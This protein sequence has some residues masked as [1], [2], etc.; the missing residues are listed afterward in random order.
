MMYGP[1]G[2]KTKAATVLEVH[3]R[4]SLARARMEEYGEVEDVSLDDDSGKKVQ[5]AD[6]SFSLKNATGC[7]SAWKDHMRDIPGEA[8]LGVMTS[9]KMKGTMSRVFSMYLLFYLD[10]D[11]MMLEAVPGKPFKVDEALVIRILGKLGDGSNLNVLVDFTKER[12]KELLKKV[13][14]LFGT[15]PSKKSNA[16]PVVKL[17]SILSS[18]KADKV[19]RMK[20]KA[21][22]DRVMAAYFAYIYS[23]F[24]APKNSS[25]K[26]SDEVLHII[27]DPGAIKMFNIV[28]CILEALQ[29]GARNVRAALENGD[30]VIMDG[31]LIL[32]LIGF[33]EHMIYGEGATRLEGPRIAE[34]TDRQLK[35]HLREFSPDILENSAV[36]RLWNKYMQ[37][38]MGEGGLTSM[39][40]GGNH[41]GVGSCESAPGACGESVSGMMKELQDRYEEELR[42]ANARLDSEED[43]LETE[44]IHKIDILKAEVLRK[45]RIGHETRRSKDVV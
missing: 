23:T 42:T 36:A 37:G 39:R 31:C 21:G 38:E 45:L 13:H 29:C 16:V 18:A 40:A 25:P 28:P 26:V 32:L 11:T 34:Y 24:L 1:D 4:R 7:I 35:K 5:C 12:R 9:I 20:N 19:D 22:R 44:E 2:K 41:G 10:P 27:E 33:V 30:R 15:N 43:L 6:T 17:E 14:G 8:G 3:R